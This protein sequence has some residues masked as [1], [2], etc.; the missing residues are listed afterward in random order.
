MSIKQS[1]IQLMNEWAPVDTAESWDNVGLQLDTRQDISTVDIVLEL[2]TYTWPL[3]I[4]S[5]NT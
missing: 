4:K 3:V 2:N 5:R 1:I